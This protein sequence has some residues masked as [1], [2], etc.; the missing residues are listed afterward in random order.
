DYLV[1]A[2]AMGVLIAFVGAK[3]GWGRWLTY[4][5]GA[6]FAALLVPIMSAMMTGSDGRNLG[7]LFE[8]SATATIWAF[9]DTVIRGEPSTIQFIHWIVIF[10]LIVWATSMFA[11]YAVFGHHRALNAVVVVGVLLVGN[12][13][14]TEVDQ[15]PLL[16]VFSLASLFL[17]IRTHVF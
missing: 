4:F 1:V 7:Q 12:M 8:A 10:G 15:L 3:A 5:I 9:I 6:V 2:A 13:A 11:S 14:F 17:L 16:V